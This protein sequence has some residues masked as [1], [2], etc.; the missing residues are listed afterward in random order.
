M[1]LGQRRMAGG[2]CLS[3]RVGG[4]GRVEMGI[5][6]LVVNR[7]LSGVFE[8]DSLLLLAFYMLQVAIAADGAELRLGT[9]TAWDPSS[10]V[11]RGWTR[12]V[13]HTGDVKQK[14]GPHFAGRGR[15]QWCS[16]DTCESCE[17]GGA[18]K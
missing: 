11:S 1:V 12:A 7:N 5:G 6:V 2:A 16:A 13:R 4:D 17:E 18:G 8:S 3:W 10:A 9:A 15:P 14:E